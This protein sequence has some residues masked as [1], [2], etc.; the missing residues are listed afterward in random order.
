M[1]RGVMSLT[2]HDCLVR[3]EDLRLLSDRPI[4]M[5]DGAT[6]LKGRGGLVRE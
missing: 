5:F 3:K 1:P 2:G 4:F 6:P